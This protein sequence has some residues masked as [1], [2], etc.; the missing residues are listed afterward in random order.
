MTDEEMR[1]RDENEYPPDSDE[2]L[3]GFEAED[4]DIEEDLA[5]EQI[6]DTQ[7]GE[8]HTYNPHQ[9]D[10]QGLTYTPP[11]DPPVMQVDEDARGV[12]VTTGFAPSM[13]ETDP[14]RRELPEE[15]DNNDA[16]IQQ[17]VER[18]LRYNSETMHL[19]DVRVEV[20][21][22]VVTLLG[23][24]PTLDDAGLVYEIVYDMDGVIDVR[25]ELETEL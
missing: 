24:V 10:D 25:N 7:H 4:A 6:F 13:E 12:E 11:T 3:E 5:T 17:D 14:S 23:T 8:G 21:E 18:A 22:G 1:D 20:E 2:R 19:N 9:A 16:D 15:V